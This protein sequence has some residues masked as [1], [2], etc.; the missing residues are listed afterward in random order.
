MIFDNKS[1]K[2]VEKS[3][4]LLLN[5]QSRNLEAQGKDIYKLGFGQSP[6]SP[7][8]FVIEELSANA[9]QHYY[10]PVQGLLRLREAVAKFHSLAD[11]LDISADEVFIAPGS[12]ILI[13]SVM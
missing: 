11:G 1:L 7:P 10:A 5:E 2:Q 4:T 3:A 13:Y 8:D 6:F 9:S 12:K